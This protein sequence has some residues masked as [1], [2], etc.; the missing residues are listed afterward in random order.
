MNGLDSQS[1]IYNINF[2]HDTATE[3]CMIGLWRCKSK[4]QNITYNQIQLLV[5]VRKV[6]SGLIV[7]WRLDSKTLSENFF[8]RHWG[9]AL[10]ILGLEN[11]E[12]HNLAFLIS[13]GGPYKKCTWKLKCLQCP[14]NAQQQEKLLV[15]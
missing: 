12:S 4:M 6:R 11:P 15:L 3:V 9:R 5:G 13:C 1:S 10:H 8:D 2:R 14:G 7:P